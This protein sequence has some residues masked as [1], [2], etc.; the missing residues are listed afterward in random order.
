MITLFA[1]TGFWLWLSL[2]LSILSLC[3]CAYRDKYWWCTVDLVLLLVLLSITGNFPIVALGKH[4]QDHPLAVIADVL[5]Y[6]VFGMVWAALKWKL[7][8]FRVRAKLD[9]WRSSGE[10][11]AR[12]QSL[13]LELSSVDMVDGVREGETPRVDVSKHRSRIV[14]WIGYW[15]VS[16]VLWVVGDFLRDVVDACYRAVSGFFQRMADKAFE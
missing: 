15:P 12:N 14:G 5:G 9:R 3:V 4:I 6:F 13:Q 2:G 1:L 11:F 16:V 10:G 8:L 7:F